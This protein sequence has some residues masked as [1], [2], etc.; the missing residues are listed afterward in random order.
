MFDYHV[1]KNMFYLHLDSQ[2]WKEVAVVVASLILNEYLMQ[3]RFYDIT[4]MRQG[5]GLTAE[6]K[7]L[8]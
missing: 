5:I 6:Y 2:R 7:A 3:I 4:S 1:N 8:T